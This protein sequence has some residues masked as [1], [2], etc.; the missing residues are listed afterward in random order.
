MYLGEI[1]APRR[2]SRRT[3][4]Q[5]L[6]IAVCAL[7]AIAAP[8]S[9]RAYS[10]LTHQALV[11]N[12]WDESIKV[13]LL[14]RFPKAT[15]EE[16]RVAHG[17][18]Y[19]GCIIQDLGYYPFGSR[20]FSNLLHYV[21]SGDFVA[22]LIRNASDV[23]ELAFAIGALSHYAAD[24]TGHPLATNRVLPMM[25]PKLRA[26]LGDDIPYDEAPKQ[27]IL[28]EFSFDVLH[29]AAGTYAPEAYHQF[30]GF[31]VADALLERTFTEIYGLDMGDLFFDRSLAVGTF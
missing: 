6:R 3:T 2:T 11:D 28:V 7:L 24:N 30:I 10:V 21:R 23:N 15:E 14:M 12:L 26:R 1:F 9:V 17:Y 16:L 31:K 19:G 8:L 5:A 18:N 13:A 20:F 25:Y 29:V 22:A 27:H 4:I